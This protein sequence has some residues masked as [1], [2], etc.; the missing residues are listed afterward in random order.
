L[1]VNACMPTESVTRAVGFYDLVA[2][3]G[4][5]LPSSAGGFEVGCN[6]PVDTV[7]SGTLTLRSDGIVDVSWLGSIAETNALCRVT[8][9]AHFAFAPDYVVLRWRSV[10]GDLELRHDPTCTVSEFGISC[11]PVEPYTMNDATGD[12]FAAGS[13]IVVMHSL[14]TAEYVRR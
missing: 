12:P 13:R 6:I 9:G 10:N 14:T 1:L 11:D 4:V 2:V 5:A 8:A 3:N 7:Y